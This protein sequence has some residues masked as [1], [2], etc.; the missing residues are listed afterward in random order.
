AGL[1]RPRQY[2]LWQ[3][4]EVEEVNKLAD[5][6]YEAVGTGW[7]LAPPQRLSGKSFESFKTA[8]ANFVSFRRI[9]SLAYAKTL[10]AMAEVHRP[11]G[12]RKEMAKFLKAVLGLLDDADSDRAVVLT[13][14]ERYEPVRALSIRQPHA[15]AIL[16]GVKRIEYRSAA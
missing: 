7:Q 2:Y 12:K 9:D 11:P 10:N 4:F 3:T 15:E 8:C 6:E 5:S 16:R 14:L 1:G 13:A